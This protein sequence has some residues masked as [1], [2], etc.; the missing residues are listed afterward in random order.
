MRPFLSVIIPIYNETTRLQNVAIVDAYLKKQNFLSEIIIVNDGSDEKT[1]KVILPLKEKYKFDLISYKKNQGKGYA[2]KMGMLHAKGEH[3][4]FVDIDLSTPIEE[5][6]KFLPIIKKYPVVIGSRKVS[7]ATVLLH[8][9]ILRENMGKVFTFLSQQLLQLPLSDFTCGFKCFSA[10]AAE[11][12]FSHLTINRWGFDSEAM[13]LANYYKFPIKEI[14]VIWKNEPNSR[15]RFPQDA[16]ISFSELI[17]IRLHHL[18][19]QYRA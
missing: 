14:P 5:L 18:Q 10:E 19:G 15:V 16:I 12:I 3:R 7:G 17:K 13:F 9:N 6:E 8:Q 1:D 11:K 4:L 2:V